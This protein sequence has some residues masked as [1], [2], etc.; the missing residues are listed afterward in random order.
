MKGKLGRIRK[1]ARKRSRKPGRRR[2]NYH[3]EWYEGKMLFLLT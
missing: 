2:K 3:L 1:L